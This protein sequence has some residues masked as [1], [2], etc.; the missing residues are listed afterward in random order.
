MADAKPSEKISDDDAVPASRGG[1]LIVAFVSVLVVAE[2]AMF[3]LFIP[4]AGQVSAMA[5]AQLIESV[6]EQKQQIAE[7]TEDGEKVEE[8]NLGE[9]GETFSP[10]GTDQNYRVEMRIFGLVRNKNLEMIEAEFETK[11]GRIRHALRMKLRNC[12]LLELQDNQLG[13]LERRLLTECNHQLSED[14]LLGIGFN[15]YQLIPQ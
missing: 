7:Q 2:S 3:F 4:S 8:F 1:G 12:E 15:A 14:L 9:F 10:I 11:S 13:L 6:R 5:E